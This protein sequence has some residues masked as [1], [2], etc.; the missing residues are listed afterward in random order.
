MKVF[1]PA[2]LGL[3]IVKI[4]GVEAKLRCPFHDDRSPSAM[5]NMATGVLHCFGCG[6]SMSA[7]HI[8]KELGGE[9]S[10]IE[11]DLISETGYEREWKQLAYSPLAL[12]NKYLRSRGVTVEQ[13]RRFGILESDE[14]VLFSIFD[15][16]G[17]LVGLQLRKYEGEPKYVLNGDRTPVWPMTNLKYENLLLVEGV[18]GVLRADLHGFKAVCTMGASAIPAAAKALTGHTVTIIFDNDFAGCLGAYSFMKLHRCSSAVLPGM[19]ADESSFNDLDRAVK[20]RTRRDILEFAIET[21]DKKLAN[22]IREKE[23]RNEEWKNNHNRSTRSR[24][25]RV[26]RSW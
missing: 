15:K 7:Y 9:I 2:A 18:F 24:T 3:H 6:A 14:G 20:L 17:I 4:T 8:A 22:A 19:E 1:D 25:P 12:K 11:L 13:I 21:N 5:F 10:K 16:R 26:S 23:K